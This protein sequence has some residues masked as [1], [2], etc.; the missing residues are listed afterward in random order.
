MSWKSRNVM[1][2]QHFE[3]QTWKF[4][5]NKTGHGNCWKFRCLCNETKLYCRVMANSF[6]MNKF[7]GHSVLI[8]WSWIF[9]TDKVVESHG[10]VIQFCNKIWVQTKAGKHSVAHGATLTSGFVSLYSSICCPLTM[11]V[12]LEIVAEFVVDTSWLETPGT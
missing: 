5:K 12:F 2:F 7:S 6:T 3:I 10:K 4:L 1:V 11:A 9:Q 8:F